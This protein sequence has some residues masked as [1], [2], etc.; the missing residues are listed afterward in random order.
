MLKN[1]T[2]TISVSRSISEIMDFLVDIGATNI[3]Q[4]FEDK[5]CTAIKFVIVHFGESVIYRLKANP[6][7]AYK[8]LISEKKRIN[9]D[10]EEKV[11]K[12][13]YMTAWRIIRDWVYAQCA[14]IKL[15]QATPLQ[16]FLSY[17]YDPAKDSTFYERVE[18]GNLKLL[19]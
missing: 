6:E 18:D 19:N 7:S 15:D 17:A 16:L 11:K 12:Q 5:N 2:T 13:S 8:L 3:S 4:D 1:Y 14:L 10:V 9:K